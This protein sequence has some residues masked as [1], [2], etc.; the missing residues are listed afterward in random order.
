MLKAFQ[1]NFPAAEFEIEIV[2]A[3]ALG[4]DWRI[5]SRRIA[6]RV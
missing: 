3:V 1:M 5:R 6:L 4:L 2:L